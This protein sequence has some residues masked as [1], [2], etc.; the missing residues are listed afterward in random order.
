MFAK[1]GAGGARFDG[2]L[3]L[4]PLSAGRLNGR[5][6]QKRGRGKM[7]RVVGFYDSRARER[8]REV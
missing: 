8:E 7:C 6:W 5:M 4:K 1:R 3:L 2:D